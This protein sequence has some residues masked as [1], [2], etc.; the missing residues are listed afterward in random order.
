MYK[1]IITIIIFGISLFQ[2]TALGANIIIKGAGATFPYPLYKTWV[3]TY[4]NKTG[5]RIDYQAVGSGSGIKQL[6]NGKVDFGA[7]DAY[8]SDAE[9]KKAP[10]QI[11]HIPTCVGAVA[12]CYNLPL[13]G[14][15][16]SILKMTPELLSKIFMGKVTNW[17]N[18]EISRINPG[19]DFPDTKITIVHRSEE[20]GTNFVFTNYLSKASREWKDN[21]GCG[22]TVRWLVGIGVEGNPGVVN[23]L[24]KI[25]GSIGYVELTWA[26]KNQMPAAMIQNRKGNYIEPTLKSLSEAAKIDLPSDTRVL[27]PDTDAPEGYPISSFTWL[28]FYKEQANNQ[29][30]REEAAALLKFLLWAIKDGQH[31]NKTLHY[32][33]L[34]EEAVSYAEKIIKSITYGEIPIVD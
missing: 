9:L 8:L 1:I 25:P 24:K 34:P 20:S 28:I 21:I 3:E 15:F 10:G 22:K 27:I 7:T 6:F 30:N 13:G 33:K 18:N 16:K 11:L 29:R 2:N 14:H 23:Y 4:Y 17:S 19:I 32:A 26:K 5:I 12:I 31:F